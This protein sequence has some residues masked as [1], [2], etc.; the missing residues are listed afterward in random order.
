MDEDFSPE[1]PRTESEEIFDSALSDASLDF[2]V[3]LKK[4]LKVAEYKQL[5]T[6]GAFIMRGL[7]LEEACVLARVSKTNL[8]ALAEKHEVVKN[9]IIFK[10]IAYK[11]E[12]LNTLSASATKGR[13]AKSAGYLLEK[14]FPA[15]FDRKKGDGETPGQR[16]VVQEAIDYVRNNSHAKPLV[17]LPAGPVPAPQKV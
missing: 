11:A 6:V 1:P 16:D 3:T 2:D 4:K 14:Q 5:R 17:A 12:L 8:E 9:F 7:P 15:E 13:Q 10:Q